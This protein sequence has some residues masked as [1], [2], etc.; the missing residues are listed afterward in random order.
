MRSALRFL[1]ASVILLVLTSG[2]Q[3]AVAQFE[4]DGTANPRDRI[5]GEMLIIPAGTCLC[6]D[7]AL[8]NYH[9]MYTPIRIRV[10]A[11]FIDVTP[12]TNEAFTAFVEDT[13]Y[14]T[15]AER[16]ESFQA[17]V[18]KDNE[19][20]YSD[21]AT[22]RDPN[23]DGT[24]TQPNDPVVTV[25]RDDAAAFCEWAGKR[26][27]T[28][29]EWE[30]VAGGRGQN[31]FPLHVDEERLELDSLYNYMGEGFDALAEV[32]EFPANDF[33]VYALGGHVWEWTS[34]IYD[35]AYYERLRPNELPLEHVTSQTN[36]VVRGGSWLTPFVF[37]LRTAWKAW[38][39]PD[40]AS[41]SLGFRCA[42]DSG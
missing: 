15:V 17:E 40:H 1:S 22:W 33:G 36:A 6:G 9:S 4:I 39:T 25:T 12:V 10:D 29:F 8:Q 11:F 3:T 16:D 35:Q 30:F 37:Q 13:E 26:L 7:E 24:E 28:E 23:G 20:A 38:R 32:R 41:N 31:A 34:S 2:Q 18:R 42:R 14:Q 21:T 5:S 27:P 19:I